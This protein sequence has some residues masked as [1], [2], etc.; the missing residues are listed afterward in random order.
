MYSADPDP[1]SFATSPYEQHRYD[2]TIGAL[3]QLHY[4]R[5][6]EPGCSVGVLTARLAAHADEVQ[7][8]DPSPAAIAEARRRL[9]DASNVTLRVG[10]VPEVWPSG[11]FDLVVCSELGYYFTEPALERLVTKM[12]SDLEVGGDLVAVHWLGRSSDH[13][14]HGS[15]V[16]ETITTVMRAVGAE[17]LA[18]ELDPGRYGERFVLDVWRRTA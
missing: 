9:R 7:A 12:H 13:L 14:L 2:R 10:A 16:H 15:T 6:F 17:H 11:T 5:C 18:T 1:W 3:P 4:R 8:Q